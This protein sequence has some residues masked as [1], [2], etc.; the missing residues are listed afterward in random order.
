M[1]SLST[2][3]PKQGTLFQKDQNND[4]N[5]AE[6][7]LLSKLTLTGHVQVTTIG[8]IDKNIK[9]EKNKAAR[10]WNFHGESSVTESMKA[11]MKVV[12]NYGIAV[13]EGKKVRIKSNICWLATKVH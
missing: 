9:E 7:A 1:R 13:L 8:G 12:K 2:S 5:L 11:D 4:A 10:F 3:S 6:T